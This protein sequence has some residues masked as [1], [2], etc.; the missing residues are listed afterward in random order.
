M[1]YIFVN[2]KRFEVS[3]KA[4]GVCGVDSP[5]E[6]IE[7]AISECVGHKLGSMDGVDL[8]FLLPEALIIPAA[9]KLA[10]QPAPQTKGI[11]IGCQSV[12]REDIRPKGN[13]GAFT[14]NRP[15]AA[16][17]AIGCRWALIGHSEERKDKVGIID[18]FLSANPQ[19][20]PAPGAVSDVVS[21]LI[22]KEALRALEAGLDVLVCVGESAEER[23]AGDVNEQQQRVKSVLKKQLELSLRDTKNFL[24]ERKV[25]VAY[26]PIWAIGPGKTPP[27]PDYIDFV[28][29]YIKKAM[30][31]LFGFVPPVVYGGGLKEENAAAICSI[32]SV[33]GGL[34]ALTRFTGEIGFYPAD[35][36]KIVAAALS[37]RGK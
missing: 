4:G 22:N 24:G 10:G 23:G 18:E 27:Q 37:G 14:T 33:D 12:Y 15:A 9:S 13:F 29:S 31:E 28:A 19:C 26:E 20:A 7:G 30:T 8:S 25:V 32:A 34:V 3:R 17:K 5:K 1:L 35:L 21:R 36:Q 6:W 16:A 2:L 11:S